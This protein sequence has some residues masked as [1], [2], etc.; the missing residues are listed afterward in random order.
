MRSVTTLHSLLQLQQLPPGFSECFLRAPEL[1]SQH[2]L[3][4]SA[5]RTRLIRLERALPER[6]LRYP[7]TSPRNL[8]EQ[9]I[10]NILTIHQ[11]S[12]KNE[13]LA[14]LPGLSRARTWASVIFCHLH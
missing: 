6:S 2:H 7:L 14:S 13:A 11:S 5:V 3:H 4:L 12:C 1:Q 10:G 9:D 8:S